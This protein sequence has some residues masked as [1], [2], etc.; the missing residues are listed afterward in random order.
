MSDQSKII[1]DGSQISL[2]L[3]LKIQTS[4]FKNA[5][6]MIFCAYSIHFQTKI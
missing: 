6:L 3:Y 2:I 1:R 4:S 5:D